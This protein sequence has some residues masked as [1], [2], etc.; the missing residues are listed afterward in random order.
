MKQRQ[1]YK[2]ITFKPSEEAR[3]KLIVL[4]RETGRCVSSIVAECIDYALSRVEL[5]PVKQDIFFKDGKQ[6]TK[7]EWVTVDVSRRGHKKKTSSHQRSQEEINQPQLT[8]F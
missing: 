3:K 1:A 6:V 2:S 4:S 8:V 7:D 5:K